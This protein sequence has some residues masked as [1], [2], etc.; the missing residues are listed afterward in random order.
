[1]VFPVPLFGLS[2]RKLIAGEDIINFL[3]YLLSIF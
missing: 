2:V 3:K 1:M